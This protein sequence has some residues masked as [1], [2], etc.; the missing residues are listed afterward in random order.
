MC[1]VTLYKLTIP[2]KCSTLHRIKNK[3]VKILW[4][5]FKILLLA[6]LVVLNGVVFSMPSMIPR[7]NGSY[8]AMYPAGAWVDISSIVFV[9]LGALIIIFAVYD[10]RLK[11]DCIRGE[12]R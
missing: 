12:E 11:I 10:I 4:A 6:T 5:S 1:E 9:D 3:I 7:V 2:I 8:A